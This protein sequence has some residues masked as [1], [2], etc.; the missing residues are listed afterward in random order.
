MK[1]G[2]LVEEARVNV[3]NLECGETQHADVLVLF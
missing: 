1:K 2:T 3:F